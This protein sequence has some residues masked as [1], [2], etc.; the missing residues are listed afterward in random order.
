MTPN[1]EMGR[2][3]LR[4]EIRRKA[5][6]EAAAAVF[7]ESGIHAATLDQ[8][9]ERVGLSKASL[10]YYVDSKE[11]LVADVLEIVLDEIDARTAEL[12]DPA[13]SPVEQL[14][15]RARAH[16][17]TAYRTAAGRMIVA[18]LDAL[19]GNEAAAV[20]LRRHE[21]PARQLLQQA[22]AQGLTQDIDVVCAVKLL[23]GGLNNIPRWHR[24]EEGSLDEIIER[25][26][27]IFASGITDRKRN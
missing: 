13:S 8:I 20:M 3:D 24:P 9:G 19:T 10:Y 15:M 25:T 21:E 14:R 26:W 17:E 7:A 27:D 22:K 11:Q 6:V 2:K 4:R 12:T 1:R 23:Y 5:I 16:V 18:N